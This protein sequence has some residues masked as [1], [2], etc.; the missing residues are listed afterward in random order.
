MNFIK[1]IESDK[2]SDSSQFFINNLVSQFKEAFVDCED[3]NC[4]ETY[5]CTQFFGA[6]RMFYNNENNLL[7]PT[8]NRLVEICKNEGWRWSEFVS[9]GTAETLVRVCQFEVAP[10]AF[11]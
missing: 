1:N 3:S 6:E 2:N 11:A 10:V 5:F 9:E 8:R 4:L 7:E